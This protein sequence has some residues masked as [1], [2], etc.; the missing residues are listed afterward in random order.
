MVPQGLRGKDV[1]QAL[2]G[3]GRHHLLSGYRREVGQGLRKLQR[4]V[5]EE[6][7]EARQ[8]V[9][10][11]AR[12]ANISKCAVIRRILQQADWADCTPTLP[13]RQMRT[14]R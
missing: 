13:Q 8:M 6:P 3:V 5:R 4:D 9:P 14:L 10:L 2:R 1:T 12:W 11:P 7:G